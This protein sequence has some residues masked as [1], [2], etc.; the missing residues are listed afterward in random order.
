MK[1]FIS[2]L[3]AVAILSSFCGCQSDTK[4]DVHKESQKVTDTSKPDNVAN[5]SRESLTDKYTRE[6]GGAYKEENKLPDSSTTFGM[7]ECANKYTAKWKEVADEYYNKLIA[8][9]DIP[10][11]DKLHYYSSDD[12]HSFVSNM[13]TNW[14]QYYKTECE[15]YY[16]TMR[17]IYGPGTIVGPLCAFHEYELQMNWALEMLDICDQL[18]IE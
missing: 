4:K 9:D 8:Y 5:Q 12:L 2:V 15:N 10:P 16:N 7:I 18:V 14:E 3:L 13:K 17:A 1:R 11:I 6:I